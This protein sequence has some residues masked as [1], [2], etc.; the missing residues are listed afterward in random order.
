MKIELNNIEIEGYAENKPVR[1][2][3]NQQ[4]TNYYG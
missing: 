4:G 2:M 1:S 3:A